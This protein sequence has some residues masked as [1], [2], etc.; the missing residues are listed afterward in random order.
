MR[1]SKRGTYVFDASKL[2]D[3]CRKAELDV[4]HVQ[5]ALRS[6]GNRVDVSGYLTG[7]SVPSSEVLIDLL[8]ILGIDVS[9]VVDAVF[10]KRTELNE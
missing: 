2:R 1:R 10:T 5:G 9:V 3:L 6:R 8:A 4:D 7:R